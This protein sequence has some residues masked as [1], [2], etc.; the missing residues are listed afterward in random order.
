M[1]LTNTDWEAMA[2]FG[3]AAAVAI[4]VFARLLMRG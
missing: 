3:V 4:L 2:K 1:E